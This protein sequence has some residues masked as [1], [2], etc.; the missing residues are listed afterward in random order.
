[1]A[2][3][4]P[5]VRLTVA[6]TNWP[7]MEAATVHLDPPFAALDVAALDANAADLVRRAAGLPIRLASKS[8]RCRWVLDR[9]LERVGFAGVMAYSLREALW[10]AG[11]GHRD[12]LV[13]YPT[14][15]RH[16]VRELAR[17]H[18]AAAGVTLMVDSEEHLGFLLSVLPAGAEP[19]RLCI[20]VDASLRIGPVHLGVRRSPLRT[21][22]D[23]ERLAGAITHNDA[24]R[25][26][27]LMFYDAQVAGLP[28]SSAAVR[29]VKR[30]SIVELAERRAAIVEA[31]RQV[32][33]LDFVNGGGTG[34]L[35]VTGVD[36]TL[37]ELAAG[38]GLYGPTL[39]D[40]YR[41]F[42]PHPSMFFALAVTRRP[43][44]RIVTTFGGG[45]VASGP[46]GAS[47][48]PRPTYP[49]RLRLLRAEGPGEV[50]TPVQG[51]AARR[52]A[53]GD[54]VWFRHAKAGE[55]CERFDTVQLV[56]P[57][58]REAV[59]TPSYRGEGRNFG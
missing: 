51:S 39:F 8:I 17:S 30:R 47:R 6:V 3:Q 56:M 35:H 43:A 26:V 2:R 18:D 48:L 54:P 29:V 40:H 50:Q 52:L 25:L 45:Y 1:M 13:G 44:R 49:R 11:L 37:T 53:L 41:D 14:V 31:V 58:T 38:S 10:L 19:I 57:G 42:R 36:P 7:A 34:S 23:T 16:A 22:S 33:P 21:A 27:G 32:A 12:I 5:V 24:F 59:G 55:L 20:D 4:D 9:V 15:D 46:A 28:D